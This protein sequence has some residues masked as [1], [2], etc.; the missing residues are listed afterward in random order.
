LRGDQL[1]PVATRDESVHVTDTESDDESDI[2]LIEEEVNAQQQEQ[3]QHQGD[4]MARYNLSLNMDK[5]L[6]ICSSCLGL[7]VSQ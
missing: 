1:Q 7:G 6:I 2:V 4:F 3:E 5:R